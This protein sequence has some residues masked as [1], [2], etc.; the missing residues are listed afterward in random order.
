M[1]DAI[2]E[3]L[4]GGEA[5]VKVLRLFLFNDN[6]SLSQ[7]EIASKIHTNFEWTKNAVDYL[8]KLGF[9]KKK[10]S[11]REISTK[12][13]KKNHKIAKKRI[14]VWVINPSFSMTDALRQFFHRANI[15]SPKEVISKLS[16]AGNLKLITISGMFLEDNEAR[17]DLLVVGDNLKKAS[18]DKGVGAIEALLGREI[19]YATF[20]TP[21][22]LYRYGMYDRLIRDV[23][24]YK[25][26]KIL[27][28]LAIFG[29]N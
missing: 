19:R 13:G 3:K 20:E 2:L 9:L 22:F 17:I 8:E 25:H 11:F 27:N 7:E 15:V 24:D 12:N 4:F 16:G 1:S 18:F 14:A 23:F 6:L 28:K 10:S 21:E 5:T 26:E 29:E